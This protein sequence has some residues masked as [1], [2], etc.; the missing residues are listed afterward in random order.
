MVNVLQH[1]SCFGNTLAVSIDLFQLASAAAARS[2]KRQLQRQHSAA[3]VH[4]CIM[5]AV[6]RCI[7]SGSLAAR[8]KH[9]RRQ[10]PALM[11][12]C[13]MARV[14]HFESVIAKKW[15]RQGAPSIDCMSGMAHAMMGRSGSTFQ[16]K[17]TNT[18]VVDLP[19][20]WGNHKPMQ[21]L[22]N[23]ANMPV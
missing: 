18:A 10:T 8:M 9:H 20:F 5:H 14:S 12:C 6:H 15:L 4:R 22:G 21:T 23:R 16:R 7:M 3:A 1:A 2:V 17:C 11:V 19:S 13:H